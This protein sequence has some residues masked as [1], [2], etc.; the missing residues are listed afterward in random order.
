[1]GR[2][3]DF[4][5][6]IPV[7]IE[8]DRVLRILYCSLIL[9]D[10]FDLFRRDVFA[11]SVDLW[12]EKSFQLQ[13]KKWL[14]DLREDHSLVFGRFDFKVLQFKVAGQRNWV[15]LKLIVDDMGVSVKA[16]KCSVFCIQGNF[17]VDDGRFEDIVD[18]QIEQDRAECGTLTDAS[19][20]FFLNLKLWFRL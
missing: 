13:R 5:K 12:D 20:N 2:M 17:G 10:P 18:E 4:Y 11:Q 3:N 1:M 15:D 19:E 9:A 16:I 7:W 8:R 14:G 6:M